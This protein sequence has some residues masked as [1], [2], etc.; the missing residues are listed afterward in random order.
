MTFSFTIASL[1]KDWYLTLERIRETYS[2]SRWQCVIWALS[3][4]ED[5]VQRDPG[6]AARAA[7]EIR[8]R[9]PDAP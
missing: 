6:L 5:R 3:A 2:L 1:P 4:L 9:Y 7:G 8:A